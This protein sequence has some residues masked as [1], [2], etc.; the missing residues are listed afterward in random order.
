[1]KEEDNEEENGE[2][3]GIQMNIVMMKSWRRRRSSCSHWRRDMQLMECLF[4]E[5]LDNFSLSLPSFIYFS[6]IFYQSIL[7]S[8]NVEIILCL[9]LCRIVSLFLL[10]LLV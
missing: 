7:F 5:Q 4:L 3:V 6:I 10:S 2:E 9:V 8:A 1:M